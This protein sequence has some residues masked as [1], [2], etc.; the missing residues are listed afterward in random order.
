MLYDPESDA[1]V[2]LRVADE[3]AVLVRTGA[4]P[5]AQALESWQ[6]RLRAAWVGLKSMEIYCND[7]VQQAAAAELL[8]KPNGP[9]L[10]LVHTA[11]TA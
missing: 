8:R 2:G 10:Q 5:S 6:R 9:R 3:I 7:V 4:P 11:K 1:D